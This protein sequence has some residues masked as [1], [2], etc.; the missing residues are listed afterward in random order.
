LVLDLGLFPSLITPYIHTDMIKINQ[1]EEIH[2]EL[3]TLCNARCPLCV[4]NANGYP[5][6]F[7]YPETSLSLEQVK[8][9]FSV[10]FIRQ[11]RLIDFCG[12]FGD[13]IMAPDAADIVE[14]FRSVNPTTTITINTNG[15]ARDREFWTRVGRCRVEVIFDLDGLED[16]HAMYRVD[17]N[18]QNIIRNAQTVMAAG[19]RAIWKMIKFRHNLHQI[20]ACREMA[21]DLGFYRFDL[22]D[23]G[24]DYGTAFD[25]KGNM[26]HIL[27]IVDERNGPRT[28][29][30][31]IHWK[32]HTTPRQPPEEKETLDCYSNRSRT[33]F[34]AANGEVYPCCYLGAFPRTFKDGPW[35]DL[36]HTQ[37]KDIVDKVN[38]NALEIGLAA[39][40]E[41]FNL[42]EQRWAV[43][44]YQDGRLILCDSHCGRKYQH[45]ERQLLDKKESSNAIMDT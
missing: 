41:W 9:I 44:K 7:G 34:I 40:T 27:G 10:D 36:V 29:D 26:T 32:D 45:W 20:D 19:S 24:R 15:S 43:K 31:I 17:T 28:I 33:I 3:T 5:H 13:F 2:L 39:A 23:H 25:R 18:W 37:L 6:N 21:Q 22:T 1:V 12:N 35:Y 16:T 8:Q 11:L 30:Q 42:I 4:R 14:Y 38:N